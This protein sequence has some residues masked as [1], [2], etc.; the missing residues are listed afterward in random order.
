MG[1]SRNSW[2]P[3]AGGMPP[4]GCL[5]GLAASRSRGG[6][7]VGLPG[8]CL[9]R[10]VHHVACRYYSP[11][12]DR[13]GRGSSGRIGFGTRHTASSQSTDVT[14]VARRASELDVP[15]SRNCNDTISRVFISILWRGAGPLLFGDGAD[16]SM[17][18]QQRQFFQKDWGFSRA[19]AVRRLRTH[20]ILCSDWFAIYNHTLPTEETPVRTRVRPVQI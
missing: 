1:K 14:P 19:G 20:P 13:L 12:K 5:L 16:L 7:L 17:V 8:E 2:G 6:V 15:R 18:D 9:S 4:G 3:R 11:R 10:P